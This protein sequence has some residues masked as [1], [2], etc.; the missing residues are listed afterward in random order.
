MATL[1]S[2]VLD[3]LLSAAIGAGVVLGGLE[4][5]APEIVLVALISGVLF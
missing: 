1:V 2:A 3:V 4:L 5:S